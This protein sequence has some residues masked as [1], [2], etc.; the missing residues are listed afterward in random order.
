MFSQRYQALDQGIPKGL[1][2]R[3]RMSLYRR[4]FPGDPKN[5]RKQ[6]RMLEGFRVFLEQLRSSRSYVFLDNSM[7]SKPTSVVPP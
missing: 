6:K 7:V 4:E 1:S 5:E 3:Q 2:Q